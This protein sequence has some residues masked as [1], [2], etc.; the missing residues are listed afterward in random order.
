VALSPEQRQR[1]YEEEKVRQEAQVEIESSHKRWLIG[2]IISILTLMIPSAIAWY[3]FKTSID[4]TKK[5]EM[6]QLAHELAKDFYGQDAHPVYKDVRMAVESC[7]KLYEPWGGKFNHDEINLYL[8]FFDDIGFY[9]EK[10]VL[11]IDVINQLFGSYI[12]EAYEYKEINKYIDELQKN[13]KQK[14]AFKNFRSLAKKLTS[15][16]ERRGEVM[17][18]I[19]GCLKSQSR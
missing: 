19:S 1:I 16:P 6:A 5:I 7:Q 9:N 2:L 10:G 14:N 8:G 3:T 4:T 17:I 15:A 12:I 11:D 18:A 13:T